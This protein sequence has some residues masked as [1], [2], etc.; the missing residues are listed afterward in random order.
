MTQEWVPQRRE[1]SQQLDAQE[2]D[3]PESPS[4]QQHEQIETEEQPTALQENI[5]EQS[6]QLLQAQAQLEQA[7]EQWL[8]QRELDAAE[9]GVEDE[10]AA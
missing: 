5:D 10:A 6:E 1:L 9:K 2:S 4:K 7:Q 8:I 3:L